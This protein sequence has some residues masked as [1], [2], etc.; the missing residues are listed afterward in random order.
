[1][2]LGHSLLF[3][4]PLILAFQIAP[5]IFLLTASK[6]NSPLSSSCQALTASS[7]KSQHLSSWH[8]LSEDK[9]FPSGKLVNIS[10]ESR[11]LSN[12]KPATIASTPL[13]IYYHLNNFST[14]T[15]IYFPK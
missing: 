7:P 5:L 9:S 6:R 13:K 10:L 8:V 4:L 12:K 15:S 11:E 14:V 1:M 3:F 2:L